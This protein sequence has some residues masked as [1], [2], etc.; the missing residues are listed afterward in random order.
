MT[1]A[2][3]AGSAFLEKRTRTVRGKTGLKFKGEWRPIPRANL[4]RLARTAVATL[5]HHTAAGRA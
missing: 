3:V 1:S 4:A 2:K 5:D